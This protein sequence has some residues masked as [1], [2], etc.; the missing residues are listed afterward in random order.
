MLVKQNDDSKSQNE[1]EERTINLCFTGVNNFKVENMCLK[2]NVKDKS[3]WY[4]DGKCSKNMIGRKENFKKLIPQQ[5]GKV[6]FEDNSKGH[7]KSIGTIGNNSST[8]IN[9]VL[10]V[11]GLK[12][13]LLS[14]SQLC[15]KGLKVVLKIFTIML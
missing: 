13:N 14:V 1:K 6:T 7:I 9:K 15:D 11:N 4:L 5:R 8:H 2:S 12:Y 10:F 3:M